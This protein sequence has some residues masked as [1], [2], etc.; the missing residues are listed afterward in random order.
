MP[1]LRRLFDGDLSDAVY[2]IDVLRCRE[3]PKSFRAGLSCIYDRRNLSQPSIKLVAH[4]TFEE[5]AQTKANL[6]RMLKVAGIL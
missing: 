5:L 2:F 1:A 3:Y 6:E 4:G